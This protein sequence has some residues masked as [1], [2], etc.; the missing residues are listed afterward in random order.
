M[1]YRQWLK[2]LDN[3]VADNLLRDGHLLIPIA[4][5]KIIFIHPSSGSGKFQH[6]TSSKTNLLLHYLTPLLLHRQKQQLKAQKPN[7]LLYSSAG[8]L[9]SSALESFNKIFS[10]WHLH[11]LCKKHPSLQQ[12]E[13]IWWR[14][15]SKQPCHM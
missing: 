5:K 14:E 13:K 3:E 11:K 12:I 10:C 2:G 7:K 9:S 1:L 6:P 15:Q 4:H 8:N